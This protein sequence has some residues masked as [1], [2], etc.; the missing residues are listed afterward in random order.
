MLAN[1]FQY[2]IKV[3]F[4]LHTVNPENF[5]RIAFSRIALKDIFAALKIRY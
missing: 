1:L 5:A 2:E 3:G 4:V